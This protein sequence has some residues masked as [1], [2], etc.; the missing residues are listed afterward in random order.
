MAT[1]SSGR[2]LKSLRY[3]D[4]TRIYVNYVSGHIWS[5]QGAAPAQSNVAVQLPDSQP[6]TSSEW[7]LY[8]G[9]DGV[10]HSVRHDEEHDIATVYDVSDE[11]AGIFSSCMPFISIQFIILTS[12]SLRQLQEHAFCT[13]QQ[14]QSVSWQ[15]QV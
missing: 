14:E 15:D 5:I 3:P 1:S 12:Q 10:P 6:R 13:N 4:L 7:K 11:E 9:S 2:R 8:F